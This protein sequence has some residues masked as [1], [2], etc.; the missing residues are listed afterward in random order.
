MFCCYMHNLLWEVCPAREKAQ[1]KRT[2]RSVL[3]RCAENVFIF[4]L[5]FRRS[6]SRSRSD[7]LN[8]C[9]PSPLLRRYKYSR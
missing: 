1:Q 3:D 7:S 2:Q 5:R 4:R 9:C 6:H 8:G